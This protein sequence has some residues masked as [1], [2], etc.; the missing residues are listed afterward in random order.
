MINPKMIPNECNE[1][2]RINILR[3]KHKLAKTVCIVCIREEEY[4]IKSDLYEEF[5]QQPTTQ[6]RN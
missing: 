1:Y 5:S 4:K 6:G 2:I 3:F